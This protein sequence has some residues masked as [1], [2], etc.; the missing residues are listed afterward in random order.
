MNDWLKYKEYYDMEQIVKE[1]IEGSCAD[2]EAIYLAEEF[3]DNIKIFKR[4]VRELL[5]VKK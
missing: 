1:N 4:E 2:P 5:I 3:L